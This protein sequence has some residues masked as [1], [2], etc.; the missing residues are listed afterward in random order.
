MRRAR[1]EWRRYLRM[2]NIPADLQS[3]LASG[4]TTLCHAW[5]FTRRDG[6]VFAFT[7]HDRPLPFDALTCEPDVGLV[8]G[9]IEKSLGLGVDTASISGALNSEAMTEEDLAR[10][11][12]DGAR[13]DLYRVDWRDPSL[14][15]HLFAGR[16][17]EVRRGV[18]AFEAEL[19][20][21]QAAFN[22]PVGRVFSRFCD[23]NLGDARCGKDIDDPA[24]RGEGVVSE[25]I[26]AAAFHAD[27]LEAYAEGWF[28]RGRLVW[29][30]GGESEVAAHRLNG[31]DAVI[32]LLDAPG[33]LAIGAAFIVYAGCDKRFETCRAKF[34]NTINFRGFPHMPGNDAVQA[35]PVAGE[36]MDGSSRFS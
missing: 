2:R 6:E 24:F 32:E 19:R 12:W 15:V 27:S 14:R 5:R 16:L 22:V 10:G 35:R 36:P 33:A 28:T 18:S 8:A 9:A 13:V 1:S 4:V 3:R 11:L 29:S 26:S 34:A 17:G 20:G 31:G 23:A 25:I 21:L 7:D 30:D